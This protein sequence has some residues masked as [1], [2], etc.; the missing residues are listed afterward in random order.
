MSMENFDQTLI[1]LIQ[2]F[3]FAPASFYPIFRSTYDEAFKKF[4]DYISNNSFHEF[5]KA[6]Q[7]FN[8][9]FITLTSNRDILLY[10]VFITEFANPSLDL[11]QEWAIYCNFDLSLIEYLNLEKF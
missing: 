3:N 1:T 2:N 7:L 10:S 5:F 9:K 11:I 8:P 4:R 6:V